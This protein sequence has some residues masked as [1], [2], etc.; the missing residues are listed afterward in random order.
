MNNLVY[1][2]ALQRCHKTESFLIH[3]LWVDYASGGYPSFCKDIPFDI[4]KIK[5]ILPDLQKNWAS[6]QGKSE[7]FWEHE[8]LKHGTCFDPPT[9][10]YKYFCDALNI[11]HILEPDLEELCGKHTKCMIKL[12]GYND[13]EF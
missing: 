11:F 8:W 7:S 12:D 1:F 13:P 5:D 10:E 3:G 2:L 6:C 9:T 4:N